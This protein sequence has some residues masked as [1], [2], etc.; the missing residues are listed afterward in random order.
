MHGGGKGKEVHNPA[1]GQLQSIGV[2]AGT[3]QRSHSCFPLA[4]HSSTR[5]FIMGRLQEL[6][7][8]AGASRMW[9][10]TPGKAGTDWEGLCNN[11]RNEA[12]PWRWH[13]AA[14]S[15][16]LLSWRHSVWGNC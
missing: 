10:G 12:T 1:A 4:A 2:K 3:Q 8:P 14:R 13:E 6:G 5:C 16:L 11:N 15:Q 9:V 7:F